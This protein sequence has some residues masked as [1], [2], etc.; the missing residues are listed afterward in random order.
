MTLRERCEEAAK[1][2]A[3]CTCVDDYTRR[4]RSDPQCIG[5]AVADDFADAMEALARAFAEAALYQ[6][7]RLAWG[8]MFEARRA[9]S[10]KERIAAAIEAAGKGTT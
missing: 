5:C 8:A 10:P 3:P 4:G 9:I 1:K 6:Y 7:T 2:I